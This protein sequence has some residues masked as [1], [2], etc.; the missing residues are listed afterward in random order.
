MDLSEPSCESPAAAAPATTPAAKQKRAVGAGEGT[1][2]KR[3]RA[4]P[5]AAG[6]GR[7]KIEGLTLEQHRRALGA[8]GEVPAQPWVG[9]RHGLELRQEEQ[10]TG[11]TLQPLLNT[12]EELTA[13]VTDQLDKISTV[14]SNIIRNEEKIEKT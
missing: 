5:K 1:P 3:A 14:R 12:L 13:A 4:A 10:Q 11:R 9:L 7:G 6:A 8:L 2:A